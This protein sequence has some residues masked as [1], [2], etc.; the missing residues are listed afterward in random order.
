[1]RLEKNTIPVKVKKAWGYEIWIH[2]DAQYCG[3]ILHFNEGG[4]FSMHYHLIKNETWYIASGKFLFVG[5]DPENAN[6]YEME[7]KPGDILEVDRGYPH[8]LFAVEE[9]DIFEVSTE[10]FNED[11]YRVRKGDSQK[12]DHDWNGV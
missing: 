3:K 10:H 8:Q 6:E 9:G 7:L 1:M 4:K 5:I 12:S 2:N 11:S